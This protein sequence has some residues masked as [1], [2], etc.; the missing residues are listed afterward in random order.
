MNIDNETLN[1]LVNSKFS[2]STFQILFYI[3]KKIKI[4]NNNQISLK[5]FEED[6]NISKRTIN[7]SIKKLEENEFVYVHKNSGQITE[8]YLNKD[9]VPKDMNKNQTGYKD[10]N[11]LLKEKPKITRYKKKNIEKWNTDDFSFYLSNKIEDLFSNEELNKNA[12]FKMFRRG[13]ARNMVFNDIKSKLSDK[14]NGHFNNILLKSY[15]DWYID[16]ILPTAV[17]KKGQISFNYFSNTSSIN[18]FSKLFKLSTVESEED[19]NKKLYNQNDQNNENKKVDDEFLEDFDENESDDI[20]EQMSS[21]ESILRLLKEFG[22]ILTANY[23]YHIKNYSNKKT[24]DSIGKTIKSLNPNNKFQKRTIN[25]IINETEKRSAYYTPDMDYLNYHEIY[26]NLIKEKDI[27]VP[28][29]KINGKNNI[30]FN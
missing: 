24:I 1:K 13:I 18:K 12:V 16:Q 8:Y 15:F 3:I 21:N 14:C 19:L 7:S 2:G 26:K 23:L 29:I 17:N 22:I 4:D 27:D 10:I 25:L 11:N 5:D 30:F 28:K 6:L 9:E 20:L